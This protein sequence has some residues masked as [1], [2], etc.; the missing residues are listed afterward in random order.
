MAIPG[1]SIL[2]QSAAPV[3]V[4]LAALLI[5]KSAILGGLSWAFGYRNVVPLAGGLGL[6]QVGEFAFVLGRVGVKAGALAP[7]QF[8]LLLNAAVLTNVAPTYAPAGRHLVVAALP[9]IIDGDTEALAR[10][11]LREWWGP[12]VD[13]WRLIRTYAIAHGGPVQAPPFHPKQAVSLGDGRFVC[14][15]HRDTGS[16]Q[17]AMFSGRRCGEAVVA[18]L[19]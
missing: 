13:A 14:G 4:L 9:G 7:E 1:P 11:Q 3:L 15:D 12:R 10:R 19:A 8:G 18:S 2:L 6:W 5:G 16:I 17:G